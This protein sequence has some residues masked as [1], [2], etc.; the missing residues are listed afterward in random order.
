MGNT[1]ISLKKNPVLGQFL[2]IG[3]FESRIVVLSSISEALGDERTVFSSVMMTNLSN[4]CP[5]TDEVG[6]TGEMGAPLLAADAP[7]P[8]SAIV[9]LK[10]AHIDFRSNNIPNASFYFGAR[11]VV[12][13]RMQR[14]LCFN[15]RVSEPSFRQ[16]R[17]KF[18]FPPTDP[19]L[20]AQ[21]RLKG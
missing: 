2:K 12:C 21:R 8:Q 10:I 7:L 6:D 14:F 4:A 17:G 20:G 11:G 19:G 3:I 13:G 16:D 5:G 9:V 18:N 15:L 1:V